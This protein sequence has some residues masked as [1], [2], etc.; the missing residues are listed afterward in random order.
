MFIND[1]PVSDN[2]NTEEQLH[3][4]FRDLTAGGIVEVNEPTIT[5][6]RALRINTSSVT[7]RG[8]GDREV[9]ILC[10]E[11]DSALTIS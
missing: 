3:T 8:S 9:K 5:L 4:T 6:T 7:F 1:I 10:P 11:Y 2:G